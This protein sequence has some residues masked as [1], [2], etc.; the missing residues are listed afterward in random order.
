MS[1]HSKLLRNLRP[2][3]F[4]CE[5]KYSYEAALLIEKLEAELDKYKGLAEFH[6]KESEKQ[7]ELLM[8]EV[9]KF[10]NKLGAVIA[11]VN[12]IDEAFSHPYTASHEAYRNIR[13]IVKGLRDILQQEK[14]DE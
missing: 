6:R 10:K 1:K 13:S 7:D 14:K 5:A 9:L 3:G 2:E 11:E 4:A 12:N 8:K